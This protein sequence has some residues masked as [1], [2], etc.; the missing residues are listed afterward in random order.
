LRVRSLCA[1]GNILIRIKEGLAVSKAQDLL[2]GF[3]DCA[4][5]VAATWGTV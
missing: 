5:G 1:F 3:A 2:R 4:L